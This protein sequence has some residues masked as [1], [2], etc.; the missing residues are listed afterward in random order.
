MTIVQ[1]AL[2]LGVLLWALRAPRE[3]VDDGEYS[4]DVGNRVDD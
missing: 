1:M 2:I 3:P 4:A